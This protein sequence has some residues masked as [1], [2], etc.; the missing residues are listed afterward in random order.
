VGVS[1]GAHDRELGPFAG[2]EDHH[3]ALVRFAYL[4]TGQREPARD[5]S[6][7][8]IVR[9]VGAGIDLKAPQAR[10]CLRATVA[11]LWRRSLRRRAGET[12][13]LLRAGPPRTES[14]P[15][16]EI[17]DRDAVWRALLAVRNDARVCLVLRY[18]EELSLAEIAEELQ[19]PLGT[20]KSRISR[21]LRQLARA[22]GETDEPA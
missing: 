11:N 12:R 3:S 13:A 22:L 1:R 8:A 6:Q 7:E 21:G 4:V 9:A 15:D 19:V 10:A 18:Y 17:D 16:A 2:Y 20:V 14:R 5:L